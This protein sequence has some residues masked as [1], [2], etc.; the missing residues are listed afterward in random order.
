MGGQRVA[1]EEITV[2]FDLAIK[3][4]GKVVDGPAIHGNCTRKNASEKQVHR[5]TGKGRE[6]RIWVQVSNWM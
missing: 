1:S 4:S 2:E 3:G 5:P 6:E